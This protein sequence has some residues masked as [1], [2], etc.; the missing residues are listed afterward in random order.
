MHDGIIGRERELAAVADFLAAGSEGPRALLLRGE[1]GIGKT[2]LWHGA[3]AR[4]EAASMLVLACRPAEAEASLGFAALA[5]LLQPLVD[6]VLPALPEP[7]R[8]ALAVALLRE[9]GGDE[10]LDQRAVSSATSTVLRMLA[11]AGPV[12]VAIDDAQW[13]D[14]PSANV[15]DFAFR[16]LAGRPVLVLVAERTEPGTRQARSFDTVLPGDRTTR[17]D[18]GPLS[19]AAVHDVLEARLGRTFTR[20]SVASIE[21]V[22]AGNPLFALEIG[23]LSPEDPSALLGPLPV[24]DR[25]LGLIEARLSTLPPRARVAL[26]TAAALRAPTVERVRAAIGATPSQWREAVEGAESNGIVEVQGGRL[27]FVHPLYA[28]AV[29]ASAPAPERRAVHRRLAVVVADIEERAR[30]LALGADGPDADLAALLDTAAEHARSRGAPE[31][32]AQLAESARHLTP[33]DRT[34]DAHRR[35]VDVAEYRFH[36]GEAAAARRLLRTVLDGEAEGRTRADAL[37]LLG[38][39]SYHQESFPDAVALFVEALDHVGDDARV[40]S[41]VELRLALCLRALGRFTEAEAHTRRALELTEA[42]GDAALHAEALAVMAR[43]DLVLGRGLDEA[44]LQRALEL[45]DPNRQVAMQLRPTKVAGDVLLYVGALRRSVRLL[46]RE[47]L[48]VLERGEDADLPFVLS[49][50]TWAECWRGRLREAAGHAQESVDVAFQVGG[51]SVQA[52][53]LA[54]AAVVAAHRGEADETRHRAGDALALAAASGFHTATVWASWALGLLEISLDD[55]GAA[56]AALES[57]TAAVER[58]GLVE[59]VRAMFL[60]DEIEALI[61]LRDLERAT[62]LVDMLD[63]AAE[64]LGR[65]WALVQARRCR[66]LLL[67]AAGDLEGAARSAAAALELSEGVEL[68]LELARTL[69]VAGQIDRRRRKKASAR[70]TVERAL[71]IFEEA[72]A[73]AW[74]RRARVELE[75]SSGTRGGSELTA[76]ERRVAQLAAA[77]LTNRE[78]ASQLFMSAKTV[79]AHLA[80]IFRKLGIRSRVQLGARLPSED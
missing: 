52:M 69:L 59:P 68:R 31:S 29:Y 15:L 56:H 53:A 25:L 58:E 10:P 44:M 77:G 19:A 18:L 11:G 64:R 66:A 13:L 73:E 26:V 6:R 42:L 5:D 45:E 79:E 34:A 40:A 28:A 9:E 80:T 57:L 71:A 16:R 27:C 4:A 22:S 54:F 63:A 70:H 78:V 23:R 41:G 2:T 30:H 12:L 65:V 8:R 46:E 39:I 50:L 33:E 76:A 60:P 55:A 14:R 20:R 72:G 38:E 35:T 47:R 48:R 75:R 32:A 7:Q 74:A 17:V 62:R 67:S 51:P 36:A 61:G 1:A 3:V 49:H 21:R 37:R 43:L 24:P